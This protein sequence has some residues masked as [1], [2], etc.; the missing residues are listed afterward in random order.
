MTIKLKN[1]SWQKWKREFRVANYGVYGDPAYWANRLNLSAY[2][3][4][5]NP[6]GIIASKN[7]ML[8]VF[9]GS[10]IPYGAMLNIETS[11]TTDVQPM[12]AQKLSWP[13]MYNYGLGEAANPLLVV[14]NSAD[15]PA[16]WSYNAE[17]VR[18]R[19]GSK[20]NEI[21][22]MSFVANFLDTDHTCTAYISSE[23]CSSFDKQA[24]KNHLQPFAVWLS[25]TDEGYD[26]NL[27][28]ERGTVGIDNVNV[29]P[30]K[31]DGRIYT[32]DGVRV[33]NPQK[34]GIYIIDGKKRVY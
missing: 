29:R 12:L 23:D 3:R 19:G 6:T 5:N 8:Y 16:Q 32:I 34:G 9:V 15:G 17:N 1:N 30:A 26:R 31:P 21:G 27:L 24:D 18:L 10:R 4:Q 28:K 20:Q 25:T 13:E 14:R 22:G 7:E 33:T 2:G 11:H